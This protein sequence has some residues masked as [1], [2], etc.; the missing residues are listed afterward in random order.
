MVDAS[1]HALVV[2]SGLYLAGD[3]HFSPTDVRRN[4]FDDC[5]HARIHKEAN[6]FVHGQESLDVLVGLCRS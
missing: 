5:K 6:Q 2:V 3:Q 1:D 4:C